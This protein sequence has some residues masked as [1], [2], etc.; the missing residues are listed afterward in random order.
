MRTE[1]RTEKGRV[2][3]YWEELIP[4]YGAESYFQNKK[5]KKKKGDSERWTNTK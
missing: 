3:V 4:V 5:R 2:G 1:D